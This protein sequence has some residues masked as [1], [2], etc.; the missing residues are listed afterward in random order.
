MYDQTEMSL[1][2]YFFFTKYRRANEIVLAY[3]YS[4]ADENY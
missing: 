2:I 1:P 4:I 3:I